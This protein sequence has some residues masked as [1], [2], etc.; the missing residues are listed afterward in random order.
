MSISPITKNQDADDGVA[1]SFRPEKRMIVEIEYCTNCEIHCAVER[2][3]AI[4]FQ[5]EFDRIKKKRP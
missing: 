2:H 1:K 3:S 4:K 5:S